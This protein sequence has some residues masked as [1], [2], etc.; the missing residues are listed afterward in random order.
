MRHFIKKPLKL[1][2][3]ADSFYSFLMFGKSNKNKIHSIFF[4]ILI[5]WNILLS[6]FLFMAFK[7]EYSVFKPSSKN[8]AE[9][10]YLMPNGN[11]KGVKSKFEMFSNEYKI[12]DKNYS[13]FN[14]LT[15]R[16]T[17]Y[18]GAN[19]NGNRSNPTL[20]IGSFRGSKL[21]TT[22]SRIIFNSDGKLIIMNK[23]K[24]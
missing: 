10:F 9:R 19:S 11:P 18:L 17:I 23:E 1:K 21:D 4:I 13:A 7:H 22:A 16:D 14:I 2:N 24:P 8:T 20:I 6:I 12:K 3:L 5:G 15:Y